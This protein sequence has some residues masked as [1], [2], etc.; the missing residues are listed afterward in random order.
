MIL[1]VFISWLFRVWLLIW[2]Q[3]IAWKGSSSNWLV[4]YWRHG[5]HNCTRSLTAVVGIMLPQWS[6]QSHCSVLSDSYSAPSECMII[7]TYLAE[8]VE[9]IVHWWSAI[10]I[11]MRSERWL[12]AD[13]CESSMM[14]ST[15]GQCAVYERLILVGCV[16]Q[17]AERQSLAGE[18]T[19]SCA[20]PAADGWPLCG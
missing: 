4:M 10:R 1:S 7:S 6:T 12:C 15:A 3:S 18:L 20:R 17:L 5:A 13:H 2:L 8:Y 16:A 14:P 9:M 11:A 19:L